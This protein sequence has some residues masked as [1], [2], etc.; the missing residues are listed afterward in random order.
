MTRVRACARACPCCGNRSTAPAAALPKLSVKVKLPSAPAPAGHKRFPRVEGVPVPGRDSPVAIVFKLAVPVGHERDLAPAGGARGARGS[1]A[2]RKR[3]RDED[4]EDYKGEEVVFLPCC[5]LY[6]CTCMKILCMSAAH[7]HTHTH[8]QEEE[9]DDDV[10][11]ASDGEEGRPT[12]HK[13]ATGLTA[14]TKA[15]LAPKDPAAREASLDGARGS[16]DKRRAAGARTAAKDAAKL[17]I[18]KRRKEVRVCL[19]VCVSLCV[20]VCVCVCV[21]LCVC[22]VCGVGCL[23]CVYVYVVCVCVCVCVYVYL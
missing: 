12:K 23:V 11:S 21:C 19:S 20:C 17:E 18:L 8:T 14:R 16:A 4:A 3:A 15:M 1:G 5:L 10:S 2:G 7:T 22:V 9:S 13:N 6:P